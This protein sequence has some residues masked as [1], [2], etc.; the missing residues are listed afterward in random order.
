[1][2]PS[3]KGNMTTD[4]IRDYQIKPV[5]VEGYADADGVYVN[6]EGAWLGECVDMIVMPYINDGGAYI[7]APANWR[8]LIVQEL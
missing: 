5:A 1:M 3:M 2:K 7:P 6:S 4:E 8:D